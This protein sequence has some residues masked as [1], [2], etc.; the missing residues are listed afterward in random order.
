MP[1]ARRVPLDDPRTE[2]L[3]RDKVKG[4]QQGPGRGRKLGS[5]SNGINSRDV[6]PTSQPAM[7]NG[8]A[9][10]SLQNGGSHVSVL[11]NPPSGSLFQA[12]EL[13]V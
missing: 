8:V 7:L 11:K 2:E 12:C 1:P 13:P 9:E 5:L 10:Q 4:A 6:A 3:L